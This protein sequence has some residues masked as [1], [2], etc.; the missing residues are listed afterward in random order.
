[1]NTTRRDLLRIT[2]GLDAGAV[3]LLAERASTPE[4]MPMIDWEHATDMDQFLHIASLMGQVFGLAFI[5]FERDRDRAIA[6]GQDWL[7]VH[8][9]REALLKIE[10]GLRNAE[11]SREEALFVRGYLG[12][13]T[14]LLLRRACEREP[15]LEVIGY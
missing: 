5:A 14:T 3:P 10:R 7:E 13:A 9:S 15:G 4:P 6:N 12:A 11:P 8:P 1:M 2:A